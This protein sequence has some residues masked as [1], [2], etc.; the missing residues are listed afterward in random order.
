MQKALASLTPRE[1]QVLFGL[2]GLHG[3]GAQTLTKV[4]QHLSLAREGGRLIQ[5]HAL[6]KL[7]CGRDRYA[8]MACCRT[9]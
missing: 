6:D 8:L 5:E 2:Y 3:Q 7:K 9:A 1:A 4:S